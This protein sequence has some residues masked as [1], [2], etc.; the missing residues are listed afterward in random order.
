[1]VNIEWSISAVELKVE[2]FV[3]SARKWRETVKKQVVTKRRISKYC[4][5]LR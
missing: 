2:K 5:V 3:L 1:M 4:S